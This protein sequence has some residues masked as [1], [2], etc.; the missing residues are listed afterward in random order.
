MDIGELP[1]DVSVVERAPEVGFGAPV[2]TAFIGE[3]ELPVN[4]NEMSCVW[5]PTSLVVGAQ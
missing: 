5:F 2:A 4:V 1:P 3:L